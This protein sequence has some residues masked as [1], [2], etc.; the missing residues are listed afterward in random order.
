[1]ATE[2]P[3]E[4]LVGDIE[5]SLGQEEESEAVVVLTEDGAGE[6]SND[7]KEHDDDMIEL[8]ATG[9]EDE[10]VEGTEAEKAEASAVKKPIGDAEAD[11]QDLIAMPNM[12]TVKHDLAELTRRKRLVVY[13]LSVEDLQHAV[14]KEVLE[15]A[16]C[17]DATVEFVCQS[18]DE[19][20]RKIGILTIGFNTSKQTAQAMTSLQAIRSDLTIDYVPIAD[21]PNTVVEKWKKEHAYSNQLSGAMLI[22]KNLDPATATVEKLSEIFPDAED[23]A[24]CCQPQPN[25]IGKLKGTKHA[26]LIYP[27]EMQADAA[28]QAFKENPVEL[29]G[30]QL[31]VSHYKEPPNN[32][33]AGYMNLTTRKLVLRQIARAKGLI[34]RCQEDPTYELSDVWPERLKLA[35]ELIEADD[36]ARDVLG[37]AKP[38][39]LEFKEMTNLKNTPAAQADQILARLKL[40]DGPANNAGNGKNSPYGRKRPNTSEG[41][42]NKKMNRGGQNRTR[43][44]PALL[45]TRPG[46]GG[47]QGRGGQQRMSVPLGGVMYGMMAQQR[48]STGFYSSTPGNFP[49]PSPGMLSMR[50]GRGRGGRGF[51]RGYQAW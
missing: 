1:M 38:G 12:K 16:S 5:A 9:T 43:G 41:G 27:D 7:N 50:G 10:T 33:P 47:F 28:L 11:E 13:P 34:V 25:N 3:T 30:Q 46:R 49:L 35:T 32:T 17:S 2:K 51:G 8:D 26:Y 44:V 48:M 24:V 39:L 22:V 20:H 14:L 23:I 42:S 40:A 45:G 36:A 29:D 21:G 15:C 19:E 6:D 4:E 18:S 31:I 37:L